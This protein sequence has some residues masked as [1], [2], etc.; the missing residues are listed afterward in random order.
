M[1][2]ANLP[3][4]WLSVQVYPRYL[5][6]FV[7]LFTLIGYVMLKK[8]LSINLVWW[9]VVKT[10]LIILATLGT[11]FV[12]LMLIH[13]PVRSLPFVFPVWIMSLLLLLLCLLGVIRDSA[14]M[15]I[16]MAIALLVVRITFDMVVLP[17]RAM[18]FKENLCRA[19]IRRAAD[20]HDQVTW[21][22]YGET[23]THQVARF[24]TSAYTNQIIRKTN[25]ATDHN[26]L[27]IVDKKLY[28]TFPGEQVDSMML[29][30]GQVLAL[31]KIK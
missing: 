26:A 19:D 31:M 2:I 7:P 23:E 30:R 10:G 18:E 29:E 27:Y 3:V 16:W 22:I 9:K 11:A 13:P 25:E 15:I 14:R 20:H 8:S 5:L 28:P 17:L 1:L 6:M 24:Y 21:L 12:M 4:Y